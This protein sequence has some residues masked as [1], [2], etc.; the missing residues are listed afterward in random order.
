[1]DAQEGNIR[2]LE[3]RYNSLAVSYREQ[4]RQAAEFARKVGELEAHLEDQRE[5]LRLVESEVAG[6]DLEMERL[7]KVYEGRL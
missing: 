3:E 7:R 2:E 4:G 1:M 6:R 5:R